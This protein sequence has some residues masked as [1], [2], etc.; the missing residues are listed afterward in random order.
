MQLGVEP[1]FATAGLFKAGKQRFISPRAQF[2]N[3]L[4]FFNGRLST[5]QTFLQLSGQ[6]LNSAP[7]GQVRGMPYGEKMPDFAAKKIPTA[8][9]RSGL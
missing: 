4:W 5:P 7:D 2:Q 9:V 6:K 1:I 8:F 3:D